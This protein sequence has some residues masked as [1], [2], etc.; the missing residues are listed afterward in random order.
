M[1]A[2]NE[3]AS[4]MQVP[5]GRTRRPAGSP[6]SDAEMQPTTLTLTETGFG[7]QW[8]AERGGKL[9]ALGDAYPTPD[10]ARDAAFVILTPDLLDYVRHRVRHALGDEEAPDA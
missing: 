2:D 5:K 1:T 4:S 7:W 6:A 9:L 10:E 8:K 3:Q